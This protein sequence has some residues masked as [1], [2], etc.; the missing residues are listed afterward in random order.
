MSEF[1]KTWPRLKQEWADERRKAGENWAWSPCRCM[2]FTIPE[3]MRFKEM[4]LGSPERIAL[5]GQSAESSFGW[6]A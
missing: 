4:L 1:G 5:A 6:D 3:Q 2:T